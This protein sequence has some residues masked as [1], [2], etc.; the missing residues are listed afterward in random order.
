MK[1][2]FVCMKDAV[3]IICSGNINWKMGMYYMGLNKEVM[4]KT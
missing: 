3:F 1:K 2:M 4:A